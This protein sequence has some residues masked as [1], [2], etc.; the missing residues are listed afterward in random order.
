MPPSSSTVLRR[1][2]Q[3]GAASPGDGADMTTDERAVALQRVVLAARPLLPL[4]APT[5]DAADRLD[6]LL[7]LSR[8]RALLRRAAC[9]DTKLHVAGEIALAD[10]AVAALGPIGRLDIR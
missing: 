6:I 5:A 9:G 10:S 8:R 2:Q 1:L 7:W 4:G 3:Q